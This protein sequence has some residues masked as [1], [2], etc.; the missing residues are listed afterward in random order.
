VASRAL[1]IGLT[2]G[3]GSGKSAVSSRLAAHGAA[4]VDT[5]LIARDLT[6][7]DGLA[8]PAIRSTFGCDFIA[9]DGSLDRSRMRSVAFTNSTA[10]RQ[11]EDIL[12]PLISLETQR[13]ASAA[14]ARTVVFDVPLLVESGRWSKIV[15]EVW[16]V[17][18][19]HSTQVARVVARSGWAPCAVESVIARQATR[20]AR[21]AVADTVIFNDIAGLERLLREVDDLWGRRILRRP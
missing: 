5:D 9:A 19:Q 13:L 17:D 11:L 6:S 7:R 16:V 18:C 15:D 10:L 21:R 14:S 2:G 1:R 4:I 8:M 12:H 3:I 20:Q